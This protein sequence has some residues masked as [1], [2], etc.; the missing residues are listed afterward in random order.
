MAY[1]YQSV[2]GNFKLFGKVNV[3]HETCYGYD[4]NELKYPNVSSCTS[5]TL[6]LSDESLLGAHFTK[7]DPV[8]SVNAILQQMNTTR[9]ARAVNQIIV[10]GVLHFRFGKGWMVDRRYKWPQQ[11]TTFN[12]TFGRQ[13]GD[14]V[15]GYKQDLNTARHYIVTAAG[16]GNVL[17]YSKPAALPIDGGKR[18]WV[19]LANF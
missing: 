2:T 14:I 8:A 6:L 3:I 13:P 12:T 10:L 5:V 17:V 11:L 9:G 15:K 19:N 18:E 7:L 1:Y 4:N 16:G